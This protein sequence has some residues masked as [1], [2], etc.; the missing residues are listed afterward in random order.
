MEVSYQ[1][2]QESLKKYRDITYTL[3]SVYCSVFN[4]KPMKY[5]VESS[6]AWTGS[7]TLSPFESKGVAL[8]RLHQVRRLLEKLQWV[9]VLTG[10]HRASMQK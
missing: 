2:F 8:L 1:E 3:M 4:G 9:V 10:L 5:S 6:S 7:I